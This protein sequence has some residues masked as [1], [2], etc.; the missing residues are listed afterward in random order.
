M[1]LCFISNKDLTVPYSDIARRLKQEGEHIVWLAPSRRWA[2][3]LIEE[4][5]P[6]A[7]ILCLAD[8]EKEWLALPLDQAMAEL[9][10]I[11]GES[12]AT[13]GNVIQM[14]RYLRRADRRFSYAYLAVARRHIEPFLLRHK[15]EVAFGE[16]TWGF[17]LMAWLL[18]RKHGIP[19]LTP[20]SA[21]VPGDRFYFADA[22]TANLHAVAE[23]TAADHA[24]ADA[25]LRAWLGRPV[26]PGYMQL[27]RRGYR[28]FRA[29]WLNEL[30]VAL[31]RPGLDRGD[32]TLWPIGVRIADRTARLFTSIACRLS[33]PFERAPW[34]E[35]YVLYALHAQ[36]ENSIDVYGSLNS[37]QMAVIE[38][39]SR[40]L[41]A[42]HRLWVKEHKGGLT[43]RSLAWYRKVK[44]LPNVRVIDPYED[45]YRMI[46]EADLVV[47][48]AGTSAYEAAL[49]GVPALALSEV[50]FGPLLAREPASRSH[51]LEWDVR[52]LVS[53][54]KRL[55]T[56][57]SPDPRK[58]AFLAYLHANSY[59]GNP[60]MLEM[61]EA[62]RAAPDYLAM[63]ARGFST[64]IAGLR[65][66]GGRSRRWS[67]GEGRGD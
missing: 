66:A 2:N 62:I 4:G 54:P 30:R 26:Q 24:Q 48:V 43:D 18:G 9:E 23:A 36:P 32:A 15:V 57:Q 14:C 5:W 51:P 19:V 46:R 44:A 1:S 7:D 63:E 13:L 25:F 29:R 37:N 41:P 61:P 47:T 64:F 12:P 59:A 6:A 28:A 67:Y 21:R 38:S 34:G 35:R 56:A 50:F 3:W 53:R 17:E 55:E 58:V 20:S 65:A 31:L 22:V 42:T 10:G 39:L 45:I 11:E 40:I 33:A 8:H 27:H 49:M 16:G 52:E 60:I